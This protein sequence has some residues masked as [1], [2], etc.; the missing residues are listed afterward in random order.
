M[1]SHDLG[2]GAKLGSEPGGEQGVGELGGRVFLGE[3]G[4]HLEEVSSVGLVM[5]IM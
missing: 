1:Q 3:R 2:D 4:R 5:V